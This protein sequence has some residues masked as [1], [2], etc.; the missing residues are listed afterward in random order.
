MSHHNAI[1][2]Q[3][4]RLLPRH[5]FSM[6]EDKHDGQRR[7]DAMNRWTQF[8]AMATAQLTGRSSLWESKESKGSDSIVLWV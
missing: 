1:F 4:L 7:S 2:S 3:I 5:E 6:L 8:I